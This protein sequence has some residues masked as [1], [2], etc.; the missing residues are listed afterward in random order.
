MSV[1]VVHVCGLCVQYVYMCLCRWRAYCGMVECICTYAYMWHVCVGCD[2]CGMCVSVYVWYI[3]V[4]VMCVCV[5]GYVLR[6]MY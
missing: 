5:Y 6:H 1:C 4:P 2:V 3:Y